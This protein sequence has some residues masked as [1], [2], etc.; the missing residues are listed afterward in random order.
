[1]N[2][3]DIQKLLGGYATGTL[4]P[5][6][7]QALFAAA[8]DD[9]EL[10]DALAREQSLRDLLRDPA[11]KAQLL[12]ALDERP[13]RW[14]ERIGGW[15]P[16]MA[17]AA[18]A[19][20]AVV[21]VIVVRPGRPPARAVEVAQVRIPEQPGK[22]AP[23][24][25]AAPEPAPPQPE[26]RREKAAASNSNELADRPA[27]LS[28][29][30]VEPPRPTAIAAANPAA[31]HLA[32]PRAAEVRREVKELSESQAA[33]RRQFAVPPQPG[34]TKAANP[35][36]NLAPPSAAPA[37]PPPLRAAEVRPEFS[38][39][40]GAVQ[41]TS[42]N[43]VPPGRPFA[44]G[45]APA[46]GQAAGARDL[47]YANVS[48][49]LPREAE[50]DAA[51]TEKGAQPKSRVTASGQVAFS[52]APGM[53][54]AVL[55]S[56]PAN[57]GVKYTILRKAET[58]DFQDVSPENLK[59]GDTVAVRFEPN[60]NGYLLVQSRREGTFRQ[61]FSGRVERLKPYTTPPLAPAD[62]EL[63]VTFSRQPQPAAENAVIR[64]QEAARERATY[65]VSDPGSAP[66]HFTIKLDYK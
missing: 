32:P 47:Y 6:E 43:P 22:A 39:S 27:A 41:A 10:F 62:R 40:A 51:K 44:G 8:L 26:M 21:A 15:R 23:P 57:L 30:S 20:I 5:E 48:G 31:D 53:M 55:A 60:D 1:M 29:Q 56:P 25:A 64:T 63:L 35:A 49:F 38:A 54:R 58:G 59:P 66:V 18:L 50:A 12:A 46:A 52:A 33:A 36:D 7:E 45:A 14:Y 37:A 42:G 11:A 2:R 16:A 34:A 65:V 24:P 28:R 17:A 3:E 9:Q 61:I 13:R 4:T 19:G